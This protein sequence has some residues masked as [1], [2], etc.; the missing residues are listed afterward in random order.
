MARAALRGMARAA[1]RGMARATLR[2]EL[3]ALERPSLAETAGW[4][5]VLATIAFLVVF[6]VLIRDFFWM[7]IRSPWF[8]LEDLK[9]IERLQIKHGACQI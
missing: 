4:T 9:S 1:L 3:R 2:D 6:R 5:G 8:L 7:V